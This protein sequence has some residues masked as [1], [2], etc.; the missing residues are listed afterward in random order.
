MPAFRD[1]DH[2]IIKVT[3]KLVAALVNFASFG[4]I[5]FLTLDVFLTTYTNRSGPRSRSV[6][7]IGWVKVRT[8]TLQWLSSKMSKQCDKDC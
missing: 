5:G 6:C 1:S 7:I 3:Q 8:N 2:D 4:S